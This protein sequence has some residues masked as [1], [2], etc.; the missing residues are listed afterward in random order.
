MLLTSRWLPVAS[1]FLVAACTAAEYGAGLIT[2]EE[3]VMAAASAAPQG[4]AGT[5]ALT[6]RGVGTQDGRF[7]LNSQPDYRDQ[8]NLTIDIDPSVER[9]LESRLGASP[10]CY[11]A[12]R[13]IIVTGVAQRVKIFF[14][15]DGQFTDKYYYQTHVRVSY[16]EQIRLA[17]R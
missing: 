3:A 1:A 2:P 13:S 16:P 8:R 6:V 12:G 10:L 11:F 14:I 7:Y 17:P 4:I 15:S 5:F 9:T